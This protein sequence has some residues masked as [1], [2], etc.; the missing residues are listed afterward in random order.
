MDST[1]ANYNV[2]VVAPLPFWE[3]LI[4]VIIPVVLMIGF[5]W[6]MFPRLFRLI[7]KEDFNP[8]RNTR[9]SKLRK[10]VRY[11]HKFLLINGFIEKPKRKR[12]TTKEK[13]EMK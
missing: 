7:G 2:T 11:F 12:F 10:A 3:Q 9:R 6:F 4:I 1:T 5:F 8:L 13:R